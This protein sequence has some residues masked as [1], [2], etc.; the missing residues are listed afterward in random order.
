MSDIAVCSAILGFYMAVRLV[1]PNTCWCLCSF[2]S[3]QLRI[4]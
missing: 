2:N 1:H 3:F 4:L